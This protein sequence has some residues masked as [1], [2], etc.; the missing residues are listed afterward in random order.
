MKRFTLLLLT[1]IMVLSFTSF[2][3]AGGFATCAGCHNGKVAPDKETLMEKYKTADELVKAAMAAKNA[4]MK[5]FQKED[6]L[7]AAAKDGGWK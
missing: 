5:N 4:M 6:V 1:L 7:E 3:V 2:A